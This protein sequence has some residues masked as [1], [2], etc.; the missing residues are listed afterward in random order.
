MTLD[1]A[2]KTVTLDASETRKAFALF[3]PVFRGFRSALPVLSHVQLDVDA[4]RATL[5]AT[6]LDTTVIVE[7]LDVVT[8]CPNAEPFAALLPYRDT[9]TFLTKK[10]GP[11]DVTTGP[12]TVGL[13]ASGMSTELRTADIREWPGLDVDGF[14]ESFAVSTANIREILPAVSTDDSRPILT[15][16]LFDGI[17]RVMVGTDSYRLHALDAVDAGPATA[18]IPRSVL[19]LAIK[20]AGKNDGMTFAYRTRESSTGPV[21]VTVRVD[22]ENV[23]I[24]GRVIDGEFPNWRGLLPGSTSTERIVFGS[25][26]SAILAPMT[27]YDQSPARVSAENTD[28]D[29]PGIMLTCTAVDRGNIAGTVRGSFPESLDLVGFN[30]AYLI[31]ALDGLDYPAVF[32]GST[33]LRPWCVDVERADKVRRIRLLMPVR[34]S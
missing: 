14:G 16:I 23:T 3:A 13:T 25:D 20:A 11:L 22:V 15:G 7:L 21:P 32:G 18:I 30:P 33:T 29:G 9:K 6:D 24:T 31:D 26:P 4:E 17:G 5:T 12:D 8:L 28:V 2:T 10:A 19:A 1:L 34:I 27:K